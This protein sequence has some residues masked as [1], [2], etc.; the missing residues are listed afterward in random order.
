[1][2]ILR[3]IIALA[4]AVAGQVCTDVYPQ[5]SCG[6]SYTDQASCE[7]A[8]C[9]WS[10]SMCYAPKINGY[11]YS[12]DDE[13]QNGVMNG[14]LTLIDPSGI[15]GPDYTDLQISITQ[16]TH[17][18]TH[19]RI[20]VPDVEQWEVPDSLLPRPGG[21]YLEEAATVPSFITTSP[22]QLAIFRTENGVPNGEAIFF[23]S[24]MLVYQ[25]QYIQ[26]VLA[27]SPNVVATFG[28]GESTRHDQELQIN[29]TYTLWNTDYASAYF[30][31]SLYG[32]HPLYIQILDNGKAHGVLFL[33]SNAV[34]A[35][36]H[37]SETQGQTIGIQTTGGI[38][39]FYVFSGPTPVDV[40]RQYQEVVGNPMM[41]P[42]WSL[43]FHNCRWGYPN[44]SYV[45]EVVANYSAAQ[46]P[47]ETQWMDIDYM[48]DYKDFTV[49]AVNFPE[50]QM[51]DF[52]DSLH[53]ADQRFVPIVDPGIFV[54]DADYSAYTRGLEQN[55]FMTDLYGS[56]PYL[57]QVWP[58]A[59][60][61]PD[62]FATNT[63]SY[64]TSEFQQFHDLVAY[65]GIWIDMNEV[66]NFCN[67]DGRGQV[68][69]LDPD[70]TCPDGCCLNCSTPEPTNK[71]DFPPYTPH[72]S[73]HSLGG[74]TVSMSAQHAGGI[75]EYYAH[76]LYGFME[77]I[78]TNAALKSVIGERPF[79]LS[80]STFL[81]SGVHTAHWTGDNNSSWPNLAAS[82]VQMNNMALFGIPMIGADICGFIGDTTEELC[83]RWIEVGAFSPFSRNHNIIDAEPQELYRWES[84]AEA[85]R[86][87]LGLRYQL[88]PVLY[89]LMYH[90]HASGSTV[91]NALWMH[92]PEDLTTHSITEQ[93]MWSDM[94]LFTPVLQ[95]SVS[96]VIGYFPHGKWYSLFDYTNVDTTGYGNNTGGYTSLSTPL[97]ATNVHVRGGKILPMQ[98]AA[99]TTTAVR[100][101]PFNILIALD[102]NNKADGDLFL[103]DG[104]QM[105]IDD[106][107]YVTFLVSDSTFSSTVQLNMYDNDLIVEKLTILGANQYYWHCSATMQHNDG[108][109][110]LKIGFSEDYVSVLEIT[111]PKNTLVTSS[112]SVSWSCTDSKKNS[113]DDESGWNSLPAGGQAG[114]IIAVV[115][116]TIGV[117]IAVFWTKIAACLHGNSGMKEPLQPQV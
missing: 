65:D 15:F 89:T 27:S 83:A 33:T 106:Y 114:I 17:N 34:E 24:K 61:F 2:H 1:M 38:V 67:L 99:M 100:Q 97:T 112:Y 87:V 75:L 16:E 32:S 116:V 37:Y 40:V 19:I 42:Y 49:D 30:D 25:E 52:V 53:A 21:T 55:V 6:L 108:S 3:S 81:G 92:F 13:M 59:T 77:S 115:L 70:S 66:A 57:G 96:S 7:D 18:R 14:N 105:D 31:K 73:Q 110:K 82:I 111:M 101:S 86:N 44:V 113:D 35:S 103:D 48:Q 80:R 98:Q 4:T 10:G 36:V 47:L 76:N 20:T 58:G 72:V 93:Y 85:S 12:G 8:G 5:L 60:Y 91:H 26:T 109:E 104:V 22:L 23:L 63:T 43:G 28:F 90:A 29:S 74:K 107:S 71:Y 102:E 11:A 50:S 69:V 39:D 88:L 64:W 9:C 117:A 95:E 84:V 68:C 62:W 56:D 78:A 51:T 54:E 79:L 94:I 46:I 45:A 41:V